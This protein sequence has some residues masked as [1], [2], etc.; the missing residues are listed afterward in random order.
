MTTLLRKIAVC[1]L[2][3]VV[4]CSPALPRATAHPTPPTSSHTRYFSVYY[5]ASPSHSWARYTT[6]RNRAWADY[7]ASYIH[8]WY[9]YETYVR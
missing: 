3:G 2:L 9:G 5:R 6:I 4:L 8:H 7:Y 1:L